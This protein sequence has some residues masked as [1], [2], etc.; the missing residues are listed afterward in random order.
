MN[1]DNG[2]VVA[3]PAVTFTD[4]LS[5]AAIWERAGARWSS[6]EKKTLDCC[7]IVEETRDVKTFVFSARDGSPFT[8]DP[9]QFITISVELNGQT[10]T[11]CYTISSPP[12]RPY[13]LSMTVKRV[14]GGVMSNWLHDS[15]RPGRTL[16]VYGPSGVFT[17]SSHPAYKSLYLSAGS[18]VT[19]LMSMT[20]AGHDLGLDRDI[21]FLH[22]ARAPDDI[23]FRRELAELSASAHR[24]KVIHICEALGSEDDWKGPVGRISLEILERYVPDFRDREVFTCG[25]AGYMR[26]VREMLRQ[27]GYDLAR[28]HQESFDMGAIAAD[29]DVTT[30]PVLPGDTPAE[31]GHAFEVRLARSGKTFPIDGTETV[32][33]AARKAGVPVPSSCGQGV[34]GT[35]K[36]AVLEGTVDMRHGGG[37]RQ[38]EID[39]GLRLLCC[40]R[41]RSDLV[42]DL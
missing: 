19:P 5:D 8:F 10:L 29:A 16:Q 9:G 2:D 7:R 21:V 6:A 12:T 3:T 11:R 41:A 18:G 24:L 25:P 37:I 17:P 22:S 39:K 33:A 15:L 26:S 31:I 40:S 36:T 20:R 4:R 28:Y 38:R 27:G 23:I 14:P 32:L 13:T 1:L 42:L 35:C 34:C 30:V